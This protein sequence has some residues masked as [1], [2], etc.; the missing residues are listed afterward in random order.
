[1]NKRIWKN[2]FIFLL[3]VITFAIFFGVILVKQFLGYRPNIYNYVSYLYPSIIKKIKEKYN[4]K[5]F[6]EVNEFSQALYAD[7]TIAG[8]G[9]D[10]QAAQLVFDNKLKKV[11]FEILYGNAFKDWEQRKN[12]QRLQIQKHIENFDKQI[13]EKIKS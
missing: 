12:I 7:K 1:M 9:S 2:I 11:N 13:Y 5:V 3:I 8:V 4:Y 6:K 10:F